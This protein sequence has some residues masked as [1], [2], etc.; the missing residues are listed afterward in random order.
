[1]SLGLVVKLLKL[2]TNA[3][4]SKNWVLTSA[5][6]ILFQNEFHKTQDIVVLFHLIYLITDIN[7]IYKFGKKEEDPVK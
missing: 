4:L 1:M 3:S 7:H 2:L 5:C 6:V